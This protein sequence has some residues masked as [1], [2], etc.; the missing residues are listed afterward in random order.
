MYTRPLPQHL[1]P[2]KSIP[3]A[4]SQW[5]WRA[6]DVSTASKGIPAPGAAGPGVASSAGLS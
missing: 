1:E 6:G 5:P 2:I 3:R 4:I